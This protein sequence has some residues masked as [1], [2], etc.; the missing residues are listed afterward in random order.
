MINLEIWR[1]II[2]FLEDLACSIVKKVLL[3]IDL[4]L[5]WMLLC[6]GV[7][8]L[9]LF[10]LFD[11]LIVLWG[12]VFVFLLALLLD[13]SPFNWILLPIGR[14][15]FWD[16]RAS[17][18]LVRCPLWWDQ[19]FPQLPTSVNWLQFSPLTH[20]FILFVAPFPLVNK[21]LNSGKSRYVFMLANMDKKSISRLHQLKWV[22]HEYL[23][24][25][26]YYS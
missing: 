3:L 6:F 22:N 21:K 20:H 13:F 17:I 4:G 15:D 7:R 16:D 19:P 5:S 11:L 9:W 14:L 2:I 10:C 26:C 8:F 24:K 1:I 23:R 25:N 18:L 12:L